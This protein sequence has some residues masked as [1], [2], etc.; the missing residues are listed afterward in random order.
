MAPTV[1]DQGRG[2]RCRGK[3]FTN[4]TPSHVGPAESARFRHPYGMRNACLLCPHAGKPSLPT[5]YDPFLFA[6]RPVDILIAYCP[7]SIC[8]TDYGY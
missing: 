2:L 1:G 6:K 4:L 3:L 5:A 7:C 8:C